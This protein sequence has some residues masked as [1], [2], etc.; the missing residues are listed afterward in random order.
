[1]TVKEFLLKW[2]G[3]VTLENISG[4]IYCSFRENITHEMEGLVIVKIILDYDGSIRV[5]I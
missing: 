3:D 2:S 5:V 1:M 4:A